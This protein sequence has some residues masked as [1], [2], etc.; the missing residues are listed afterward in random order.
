MEG[1]CKTGVQTMDESIPQEKVCM[2]SGELL[3]F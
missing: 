1:G 3:V 2:D